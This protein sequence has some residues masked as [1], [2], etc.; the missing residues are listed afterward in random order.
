MSPQESFLS[1][2]LQDVIIR[3]ARDIKARSWD[4]INKEL[5][6]E[7]FGARTV[8]GH[9]Q[10]I[11]KLYL[12]TQAI[13]AKSLLNEPTRPASPPHESETDGLLTPTIS[14]STDQGRPIS[15]HLKTTDYGVLEKP[16]YIQIDID[17]CEWAR[18][19]CEHC[20][21]E[22]NE[23]TYDALERRDL[24]TRMSGETILLTWR[25]DSIVKKTRTTLFKVV[26]D[27]SIERNDIRFGRDWL[28]GTMP[29][30]LQDASHDKGHKRTI[31]MYPSHRCWIS[32]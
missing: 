6:G 4:D 24:H 3:L 18:L 22:E 7:G 13:Y 10:D 16:E 23:I 19:S 31:G 5:S 11:M 2:A 1:G 28:N 20:S 15:L 14:T 26:S 8:L 32:D 30:K 9:R 29:K 27:V 25:F 21:N 17:G 12:N